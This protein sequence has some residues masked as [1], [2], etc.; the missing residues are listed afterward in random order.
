MPV[1]FVNLMA[2]GLAWQ[3]LLAIAALGTVSSTIFLALVLIAAFRYH[4]SGTRAAQNTEPASWPRGDAAKARTRDGAATLRKSLRVFF[5]RIIPNFEILI[6]A[7]DEENPA[8]RVAQEVR[9]KYPHVAS[10]VVLSGP[11]TWPNAKVFSLDKM[12]QASGNSYL[13]ITDSDILGGAPLPPPRHSA[14]P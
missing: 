11:P 14:A 3:F 1:P 13:V 8:L 10:R 7:R 4:S 9:R 2:V 5:S 6:G 12:I